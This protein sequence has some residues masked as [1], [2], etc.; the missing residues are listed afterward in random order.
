MFELELLDIYTSYKLS[1][2][3][4][5]INSNCFYFTLMSSV[6]F[7]LSLLYILI[8][9]P[10]LCIVSISG[11]VTDSKCSILASAYAIYAHNSVILTL[12][13]WIISVNLFTSLPYAL[14]SLFSYGFFY[15]MFWISSYTF[16]SS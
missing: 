15:T 7:S 9:S 14:I 6:S 2:R 8:W 11:G 3:N 4:I 10:V 16:E 12:S 5:S 13:Y 1:D